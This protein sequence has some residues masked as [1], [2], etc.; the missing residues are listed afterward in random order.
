[1]CHLGV[2]WRIPAGDGNPDV[3]DE[4]I[5]FPGGGDGDPASHCHGPQ[6]PLIQENVGHLS[7]LATR[8]RLG[9]PRINTFSDSATPGKQSY[10]LSSGTM[11]CNASRITT[12]NQWSEKV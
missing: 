12:W 4:E 9:T 6:V 2:H 3:E 8:L 10:P 11:R 1:M 5:T 7:T